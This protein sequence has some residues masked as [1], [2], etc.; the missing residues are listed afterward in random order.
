MNGLLAPQAAPLSFISGGEQVTHVLEKTGHKAIQTQYWILPNP[1]RSSIFGVLWGKKP[2]KRVT[3]S[4]E[5]HQE[6]TIGNSMVTW[7]A[8]LPMLSPIVMTDRLH[9]KGVPESFY[10]E[11]CMLV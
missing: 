10:C 7:K 2:R 11:M 6:L 5:E 8:W 9:Q 4:I 1:L 3:K